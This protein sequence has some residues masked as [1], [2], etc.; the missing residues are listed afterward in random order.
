[1]RQLHRL[2]QANRGRG[3]FRAEGNRLVVY[4][5]IVASD[6]DAAWLGGISAEAFARELRAMAGDV[7]LRINS[8]GGDVFAARAMAQAMREHPGKITAHVDGVAASAASLLAVS[9]SETVMAP[10]AMMMIHEA[11]TIA[12]GNKGDFLATAAL[13][14]KIDASIVETYQAKAGGDPA[15]WAALM[16]AE[17]WYTGAEAVEAGLADR[18]AEDKPAAAQAAWDLGVYDNAPAGQVQ[19]QAPEPAPEPAPVLEP[20]Q[21]EAGPQTEIEHRKRLLALRLLSPAA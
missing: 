13:L 7:E 8:P 5:V 20:V 19:A 12:L 2:I 14:E 17:T 10:G 6:S 3:A 15:E 18:V 16:A 1:M 11:W 9:A 4:D 21:A